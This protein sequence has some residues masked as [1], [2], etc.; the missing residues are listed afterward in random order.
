[1]LSPRNCVTYRPGTLHDFRSHEIA[2]QLTLLDAEL[3]YK[4]E[5]LCLRFVQY[6]T[7]KSL[8]IV[9]ASNIMK[10]LFKMDEGKF[11]GLDLLSVCRFNMSPK[12]HVHAFLLFCRFLRCCSGPRS[13]MRR[14]VPT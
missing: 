9:D 7:L 14:R 4:I 3:F 12:P 11:S 2:D 6:S 8:G 13:R 10:L 1:M 5:V